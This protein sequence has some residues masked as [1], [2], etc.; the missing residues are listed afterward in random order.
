[1]LVVLGYI[2]PNFVFKALKLCYTLW[3]RYSHH[4]VFSVV[5]V[6]IVS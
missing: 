3:G 6:N 5:V 2:C 1:M 4:S